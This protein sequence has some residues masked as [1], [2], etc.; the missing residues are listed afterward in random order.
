MIYY[1]N[2]SMQIDNYAQNILN[3]IDL[4]YRDCIKESSYINESSIK[5]IIGKIISIF[6]RIKEFFSTIL[7]KI[8]EKIRRSNRNNKNSIINKIL[9]EI[10]DK[11]LTVKTYQTNQLQSIY[12]I[13][14]E[15]TKSLNQVNFEDRNFDDNMKYLQNLK[16]DDKLEDIKNILDNKSEITKSPDELFYIIKN[17]DRIFDKITK[18]SNKLTSISNEVEKEAK[19][20]ESLK[21]D[22]SGIGVDDDFLTFVKEY[23]ECCIKVGNNI[24]NAVYMIDTDIDHLQL[25]IVKAG[26]GYIRGWYD[27]YFE[28]D[29]FKIGD[30]N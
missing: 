6:K 4:I 12:N 10:K 22:E 28:Y 3:D 5:G 24:L 17:N 9:P 26:K 15:L 8:R 16:I 27:K 25:E 20:L 2:E 29:K 18:E 11:S 13:I 30:N 14:A 21:N 19:W 23:S 7:N 1:I